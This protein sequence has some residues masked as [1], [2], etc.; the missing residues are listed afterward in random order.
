MRDEKPQ[1]KNPRNKAWGHP[2]RPSDVP[3]NKGSGDILSQALTL[4]MCKCLHSEMVHVPF[5]LSKGCKC[6]EMWG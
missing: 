5:C 4:K 6:K 1:V 3:K 2:I